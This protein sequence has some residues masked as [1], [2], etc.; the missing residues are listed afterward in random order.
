MIK[1]PGTP[2]GIPA[3]R[4][5]IAD[6]INVNIT[7]LFSLGRYEEVI[8]AYLAGLE[9]RAGKGLPI[10]SIASVASFF[11]S[12]VDTEVDKRIDKLLGEGGTQDAETRK[13][14][15]W[16]KG[17]VAIANAKL[18]YQLF[19]QRFSGERWQRLQAAGARL[20]RP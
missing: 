15:E 20:Q 3:I 7:L 10:G 6:G 2:Q 4:Q 12:R 16:L 9:Q 14:L 1:V 18:A 19:R 5:L 17:K 11:V 8:E 13:K